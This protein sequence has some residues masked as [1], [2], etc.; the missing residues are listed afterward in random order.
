MGESS[1]RENDAAVG[2]LAGAFI[3]GQCF[4]P[5]SPS[6][7]HFMTTSIVYFSDVACE[8]NQIISNKKLN[9]SKKVRTK[10]FLCFTPEIEAVSQKVQR[11][12]DDSIFVCSHVI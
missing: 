7:F 3:I 10:P 2:F 5:V 9:S 6:G 1:K 4:V 11:S 8:L 12:N